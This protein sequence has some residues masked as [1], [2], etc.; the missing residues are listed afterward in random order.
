MIPMPREDTPLWSDAEPLECVM[1]I[2]EA[3]NVYTFS[4]RPPSGA[5]FLFRP[6]QFLTLDLPVPGGS[7]QRTFTISSSPSSHSYV[8][9]T[10]KLQEG[11]IG[12]KWM[13]EHLVPGVR[14]KA[15]GPAGV[16]HLPRQPDDKYLFIAAGSGITPM[17][18]MSSFLFERG[19]DPD[20]VLINC[21]K[22]PRELIFRK[23]L[24]YMASRLGGL[25][26]N[27]VVGEDDPYDAW[28]GYR[29]RFNQLML[30]L[31][32]PDYLEREVYCCG[33]ESFMTSVREMLNALGYDMARYHQ[34]S[35]HA[36]AAT[37]ADVVEPKDV[38]PQEAASAQIRFTRSGVMAECG[39]TDTVLAVAKASG[40]NIPSGCTFG[41]C[42]TCKVRKIGGEVHMLHNGG[43]SEE[44][45]AEGYIL[46]CCSNPMG[47]V[48]IEI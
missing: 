15:F 5:H 36:P 44:D 1:V 8:T 4:F 39:E 30:G 19:E 6:G 45:I 46:A 23:R 12:T 47:Q 10:A 43:I 40:L 14:I 18:S 29:G 3:P 11:S 13:F 27:F 2:P 25:K 37:L 17:M 38:F 21:A 41:V 28:T 32:A 35:F 48:E 31:M 9:V 20:I 34:E 26:L 7:V 33:P 16:F 42:G 24:E 22:R